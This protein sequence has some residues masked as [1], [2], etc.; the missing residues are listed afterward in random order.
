MA[1]K[2]KT[3]PRTKNG[4]KPTHPGAMLM[5]EWLVPYGIERL[6]EMMRAHPVGRVMGVDELTAL[7]NCEIDITPEMADALADGLGTTRAFWLNLQAAYDKKVK[8]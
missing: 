1:T 5:H 8:K 4:I 6:R 2:K 3:I 7:V